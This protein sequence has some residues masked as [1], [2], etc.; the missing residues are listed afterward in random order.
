M[1]ILVIYFISHFEWSKVKKKSMR[2][3]TNTETVRKGGK[4]RNL[5]MLPKTILSP[6]R[7]NLSSTLGIFLSL[8]MKKIFGNFLKNLEKFL[9]LNSSEKEELSQ[10]HL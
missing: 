10:D 6:R 2:K 1:L 8:G 9:M 5:P 4:D 3:R 7:F